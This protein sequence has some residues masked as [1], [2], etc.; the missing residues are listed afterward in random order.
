MKTE[1]A[2]VCTE[3]LCGG[4]LDSSEVLRDSVDFE[5]MSQQ[6]TDAGNS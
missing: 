3:L 4:R 6:S 2:V 5:N 1:Q